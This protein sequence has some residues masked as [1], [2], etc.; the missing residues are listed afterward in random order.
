MP[1]GVCLN[2]NIPNIEYD[3]L[4]GIKICRQAKANWEEELDER[5]D[6]MGNSY[7]WLTGVFKNYDSGIDTD[8]WALANNYIAVVP[9]HVDLTSYEGI[10]KLRDWTYECKI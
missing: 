7:F 8:E 2:V 3:K 4:N 9:I 1:E 6:P 5:K 10:K